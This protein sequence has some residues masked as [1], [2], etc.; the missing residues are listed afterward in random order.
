MFVTFVTW[1]VHDFCHDIDNSKSNGAFY[2]LFQAQKVNQRITNINNKYF[3]VRTTTYSNFK[4]KDGGGGLTD[5]NDII[6]SNCELGVEKKLHTY[7]MKYRLIF[8][9]KL[10]SINRKND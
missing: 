8:F 4:F 10:F 6:D 5:F 7:Q 9:R 3:K 2:N 1:M